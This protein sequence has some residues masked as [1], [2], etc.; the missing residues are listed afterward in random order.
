M[1]IFKWKIEQ[2]QS[3]RSVSPTNGGLTA[4]DVKG[5]LASTLLLYKKNS[6]N[7]HFVRLQMTIRKQLNSGDTAGRTV[8]GNLHCA[9]GIAA[10]HFVI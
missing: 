1:E 4:T 6:S 8:G 7:S 10:R 3:S 5:V 9:R 2:S